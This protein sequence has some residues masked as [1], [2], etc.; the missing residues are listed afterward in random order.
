MLGM[1]SQLGLSNLTEQGTSVVMFMLGPM[2]LEL[3]KTHG[4]HGA[5][6]S[7]RQLKANQVNP[8]DNWSMSA[9]HQSHQ[10]SGYL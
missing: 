6:W 3:K 5:T 7:S 8:V 10:I 9:N 4:D 2:S 1:K